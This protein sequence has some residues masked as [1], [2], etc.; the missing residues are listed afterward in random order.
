M[1]MLI[2]FIT[3]FCHILMTE[4]KHTSYMCWIPLGFVVLVGGENAH[5][6][7]VIS[8]ISKESGVAFFWVPYSALTLFRRCPYSGNLRLNYLLLSGN[9]SEWHFLVILKMNGDGWK[10]FA[11]I[12][13]QKCHF[14]SSVPVPVGVYNKVCGL[15]F[16]RWCNYTKIQQYVNIHKR[17]ALS[18]ERWVGSERWIPLLDILLISTSSQRV[19]MNEIPAYEVQISVQQLFT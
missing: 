18:A 19:S 15:S 1:L 14:L 17:K 5:S 9:H 13:L 8:E 16:Q 7:T 6:N 4:S 2:C 12:A 3:V 10:L 11:K